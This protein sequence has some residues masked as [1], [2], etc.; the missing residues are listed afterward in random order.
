[1]QS[2]TLQDILKPCPFCGS[3]VKRHII[4]HDSA[5]WCSRLVVYCECGATIEIEAD[6]TF[7]SDGVPYR[8]GETA[9]DKWN[10]RK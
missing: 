4:E 3:K 9:I 2:M 6:G 1:M 7:Y 10:N 8:F 5:G